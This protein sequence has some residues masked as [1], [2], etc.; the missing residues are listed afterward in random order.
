LAS[1][2]IVEP[3]VVAEASQK[4]LFNR[5]T[6]NKNREKKNKIRE[7]FCFS[8]YSVATEKKS[9][10]GIFFSPR[11]REKERERKRAG[12]ASVDGARHSLGYCG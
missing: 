8:F 3:L 12:A 9:S 10:F 11:K 1:Q 4:E 2:R 7:I 6:I 5:E